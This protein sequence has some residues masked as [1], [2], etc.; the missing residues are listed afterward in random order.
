MP[1]AGAISFE[2]WQAA[3][4]DEH[5]LLADPRF[6]NPAGLDFQIRPVIY[7]IGVRKDSDAL[8]QA[9]TQAL[10]SLIEDGSYDD[11]IRRWGADAGTW[12][13]VAS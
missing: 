1:K 10:I 2:R 9:L 5:S 11:V 7:G 13:E 8:K 6:V 3:G 12:K 4:L